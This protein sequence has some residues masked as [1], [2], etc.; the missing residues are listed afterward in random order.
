MKG[1]KYLLN[2]DQFK[3]KKRAYKEDLAGTSEHSR[4]RIQR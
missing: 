3:G 2:R 1:E 4:I